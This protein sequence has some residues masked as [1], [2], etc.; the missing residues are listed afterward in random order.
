MNNTYKM[1]IFAFTY[2]ISFYYL[3]IFSAQNSYLIVIIGS[4]IGFLYQNMISKIRKSHK[5]KT[6]YEINKILLGNII[7]SIVN[8]IFVLVFTLLTIILFWYISVFLKTNFFEETPIM[9][10]NVVLILPVIYTI[11]KN[12]NC[13][14]KANSIFAAIV[15]FLT[16]IAFLF[17]LPQVE[18]SNLKPFEEV[19]L[20]NM[21]YALFGFTTTTFLPAYVV[22]E[23]LSLKD[24]FKNIILLT[25]IV[26]FTYTV[27]GNS[28]ISIVDFPQFFVLRKIK[29][30]ATRIDSLIIIGWFLSI[31]VS[32]MSFILF[33][34][35]YLKY[36]IDNIKPEYSA[37][38]RA[39]Q[40][41][42]ADYSPKLIQSEIRMYHKLL[43]YAGTADLLCLIDGRLIL[44]YYKSTAEIYEMTCRVQLEAYLQALASHGIMPEEKWILHLKRDGSYNIGS[45]PIRDAEAWRVFGALKNVHDYLASYNTGGNRIMRHTD[46]RQVNR[47]T[48]D[49]S[50]L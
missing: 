16:I 21:I 6:I 29:F 32:N 28:I 3:K 44:I 23:E 33:I 26:F 27:L 18:L 42:W 50:D 1:M 17:L 34:K 48:E 47:S 5:N 49:I 9:L 40:S 14:F 10:I 19:K 41:F 39:F 38:F 30:N 31:Y 7:G 20:S 46:S 45:F 11:N 43:R 35:N 36:E 37:Y 2:G 4:I 24:L 15:L 25:S 22:N 12:E 8:I 13:F